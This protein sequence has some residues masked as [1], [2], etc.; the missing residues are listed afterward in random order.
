MDLEHPFISGD[1]PGRVSRLVSVHDDAYSA[2][3]DSHA[4]VVCTEWEEFKAL[5]Y[6]RI[7]ST[8]EKPA[9]AFDGRRILDHEAM[10]KLGFHVETIGKRMT[11]KNG[12]GKN[13]KTNG[14]H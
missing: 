3:A 4:I 12:N 13:G 9:F 1:D 14:H 5:D 6:G 11:E 8:M 2:A 10:V 7:Y